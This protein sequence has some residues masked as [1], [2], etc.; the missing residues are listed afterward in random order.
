MSDYFVKAKQAEA[1]GRTAVAKVLYQMIARGDSGKL[2]REAQAR[3][4][5]L[6]VK[7]NAR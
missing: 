4:A 7:T 3:L 5:A 1:D 6:G 2:K